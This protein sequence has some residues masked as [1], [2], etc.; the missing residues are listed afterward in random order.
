MFDFSW[1]AWKETTIF[2]FLLLR[3]ILYYSRIYISFFLFVSPLLEEYGVMF[4]MIKCSEFYLEPMENLFG[5]TSEG[6]LKL[7]PDKL[8]LPQDIYCLDVISRQQDNYEEKL[9]A[10][11][12]FPDTTLQDNIRWEMFRFTLL[13]S[14]VLY[15][16]LHTDSTHL[17]L[18]IWYICWFNFSTSL[19]TK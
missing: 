5:V 14:I 13:H 8:Y 6:E 4:K 15:S 17:I 16:K 11:I 10:F 18:F 2:H 1:N 7:L 19:M 9:Y 12:C 3:F